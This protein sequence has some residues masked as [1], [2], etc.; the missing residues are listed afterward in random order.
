MKKYLLSA[1]VALTATVA[2]AASINISK[3]NSI[4]ADILKYETTPIINAVNISFGKNTNLD[5]LETLNAS[6]KFSATASKSKW[7]KSASTVDLGVSVKTLKVMEEESTT[8]F[9]A[10]LGSRTNTLSLYRYVANTIANDESQPEDE[11]EQEFR[12]LA[13]KAAKVTKLDQIPQQ[14]EQLVVLIKKALQADQSEHNDT[15]KWAELMDSLVVDTEKNHKETVAVVLKTTKTVAFSD[16][17]VSR[18]ALNIT[19]AGISFDGKVSF[20]ASNEMLQTGAEM[21]GNFLSSIENADSE[22]LDS[23]REMARGYIGLAQDIIA[24]SDYED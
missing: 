22:T 12:E 24:G 20:D 4:I 8:E 5:S 18:L 23:L 11:F 2:V 7:S 17:T 9:E 15:A 14:L 19:K 13:K 6:A 1:A 3:V 10:S 21:V 16:V